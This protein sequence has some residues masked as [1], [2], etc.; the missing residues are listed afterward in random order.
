MI[1]EAVHTSQSKMKTPISGRT[2]GT[3]GTL[4]PVNSQLRWRR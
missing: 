2:G 1:K 4:T 3:N